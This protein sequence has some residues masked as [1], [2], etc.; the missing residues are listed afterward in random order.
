PSSCSC[1]VRRA[2]RA[3]CRWWSTRSPSAERPL[4]HGSKIVAKSDRQ[5]A[6]AERVEAHLRIHAHVILKLGLGDT[7]MPEVE[8]DVGVIV[9]GIR[10]PRDPLIGKAPFGAVEPEIGLHLRVVETE[11]EAERGLKAAALVQRQIE[12]IVA[13]ERQLVE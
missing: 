11:T 7:Q 12:Q 9:E 10:K 13:H 5:R 2:S 4:R 8:R 1:S 6:L 3:R